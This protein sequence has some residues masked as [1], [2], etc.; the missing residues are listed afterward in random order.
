MTSGPR[1]SP[2]GSSFDPFEPKLIQPLPASTCGV[3]TGSS[4]SSRTTATPHIDPAVEQADLTRLI[5]TQHDDAFVLHP[6]EFALGST[7]E[8]ITLPADAAGRLEGKSSPG[9]LGLA[10]RTRRRA[11]STPGFSGHRPSSCPT[12][13]TLPIKLWPGMK[14]GQLCLFRTSSPAEHPL[15]LA[16]L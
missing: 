15:R 12:W 5:E 8:V 10:G 7:F 1:S 3:S 9:R 6:G 11:G 16:R 4:G 13:Q 2:G 14:I